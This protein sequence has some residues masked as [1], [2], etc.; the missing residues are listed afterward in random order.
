MLKI[1]WLFLFRDILVGFLICA[2]FFAARY[3]WR[4]NK[5]FVAIL[6]TIVIIGASLDIVAVLANH[7]KMPIDDLRP[8]QKNRPILFLNKEKI[9][10]DSEQIGYIP[11][12]EKTRL[13]FLGDMFYVD[14]TKTKTIVVSVGD[15]TAAAAFIL[16]VLVFIQEV[17]KYFYFK[18]FKPL[19]S[20]YR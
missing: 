3:C 18:H 5:K 6:I 4:Q 19:N 2:P 13:N 10:E 16:L 14:L 20:G 15:L 1:Y 17:F 8:L 12:S 7:G 11:A 9:A